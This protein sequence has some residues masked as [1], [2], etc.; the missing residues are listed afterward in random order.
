MPVTG[1][2]GALTYAKISDNAN[3]FFEYWAVMPSNIGNVTFKDIYIDSGNSSIMNLAEDAGANVITIKISG[4]I[5][6]ITSNTNRSFINALTNT[7]IGPY[8]VNKFSFTDSRLFQVGTILARFSNAFPYYTCPAECYTQIYLGNAQSNTANYTR[9]LVSGSSNLEQQLYGRDMKFTSNSILSLCNE[10]MLAQTSVVVHNNSNAHNRFLESNTTTANNSIASSLELDSTGN[11]VIYY[12]FNNDANNKRRLFVRKLDKTTAN[13]GFGVK[14]FPVIWG[15]GYQV[16]TNSNLFSTQAKLDSNDNIYCTGYNNSNNYG[17][18]LKLDSNGNISW[19]KEVSNT[20]LTGISLKNDNDIYITGKSGN[21]IWIA[22]FDNTGNVIWQNEFSGSN[23]FTGNQ[24]INTL[25]NDIYIGS[26][27]G[28][29]SLTIKIP[30]NGNILGN[31]AYTFVGTSINLTYATSNKTV[32]NASLST[33]TP[34]PNIQWNGNYTVFTNQA[35]T[36][37]AL[38]TVQQ[39]AIL[40]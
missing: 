10:V 11:I 14:Y 29:K 28:N 26:T 3:P 1:T 9:P 25:G 22:Q 21:N 27:F 17:I 6:P 4:L 35:V 30:D 37:T 18:L 31:G 15:Y 36:N 39:R 38:S 2:F 34:G 5:N 20:Y 7:I 19:Q 32:S 23:A 40:S 16:S 33:F 12:D 13:N 8:A 24:K